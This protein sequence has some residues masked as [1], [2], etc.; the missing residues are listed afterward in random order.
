MTIRISIQVYLLSQSSAYQI[1]Y[2]GS[3]LSGSIIASWNRTKLNT[4]SSSQ[5][6]GVDISSNMSNELFAAIS[7]ASTGNLSVSYYWDKWWDLYIDDT[8]YSFSNVTSG[9][10][11]YYAETGKY[12]IDFHI[13]SALTIYNE[14]LVLK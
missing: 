11:F 7:F 14:N 13:I 6:C 1:F 3:A 10:F 12:Y 9:N 5:Q 4:S 2:S 8:Q